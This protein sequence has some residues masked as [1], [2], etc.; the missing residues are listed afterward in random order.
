MDNWYISRNN[1]TAGP[2]S[3]SQIKQFIAQ[4]RLVPT[5]YVCR[6]GVFDWVVAS[7]VPGLFGASRPAPSGVGSI[8]PPSAQPKTN[9]AP[10]VQI[11]TSRGSTPTPAYARTGRSKKK[12]GNYLPLVLVGAGV[13]IIGPVLFMAMN[14]SFGKRGGGGGGGSAQ[15]D[16]NIG[17]G[18]ISK[19]QL[20]SVKKGDSVADVRKKLGKP[21]SIMTMGE[22]SRAWTYVVVIPAIDEYGVEH[23]QEWALMFDRPETTLDSKLLL[24]EQ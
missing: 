8:R 23:Y 19:Q 7:S 21:K 2:F 18:T 9:P 22:N 24:R 15:G 4:G 11:D 13:L 14:G 1:Q 17:A 10:F 5:D 3:D 20:S 6:Q 12:S 16:K